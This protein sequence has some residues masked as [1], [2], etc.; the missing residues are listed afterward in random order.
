MPYEIE[1]L[2]GKPYEPSNGDEGRRFMAQFCAYCIREDR[3]NEVYCP[4]ATGALLG[5]ETVEWRH[6][7][8]RKAE[9]HEANAAR[10]KALAV[11]SPSTAVAEHGTHTGET[12]G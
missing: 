12:D 5:E 3:D 10:L 2:A 4:I 8:R 7:F 6:D 11:N 1:A 9:R